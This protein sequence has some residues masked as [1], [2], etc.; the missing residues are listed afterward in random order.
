MSAQA[1]EDDENKLRNNLLEVLNAIM[2]HDQNT[3]TAGEQQIKLLEVLDDFAVILAELTVDENRGLPIR[4]L[5]SLVLKQY[6]EC[7]WNKLADKFSPPETTYPA[8]VAIRQMLPLGL[9]D[10]SSKIRSSI[11]YAISAI[12]HWDWP[13]EWP[14][15]FPQLM[16]ALTSGSPSHVHGAMRVLTEFSREL[17]DTQMPHVAPVVLPELLK[18]FLQSDTYSIRT[19]SRAVE[20]F[21]TCTSLI[22]SADNP[23]MTNALLP[24]QFVSEFTQAF[25]ESLQVPNGP[26][27]DCGLKK[28][29]LKTLISMIRDVP[30]KMGSMVSPVLAAVWQQL[31]QGAQYYV[32]REVNCS[33]EDTETVFD[34]DGEALSFGNLVY[35]IFD[36]VESLLDSHKS[37]KIVKQSLPELIYHLITY[38]QMTE[39]QVRCWLENP[40]QFVEDE[41]EETFSFSVR[42]SAQDLFMACCKEFKNESAVALLSVMDRHLKEANTQRNNGDPH[43]WKIHE[44]SFL[45]LG[46]VRN[47]ILE[48]LEKSV[49]Q[50]DFSS[51]LNSIVSED[52]KSD[53]SFLS[54]RSLWLASRFASLMPQETL[55]NFLGATV[56][57]LQPDQSPV[58]RISS[59]RA[60][61]AYCDH[62]PGNDTLTPFVGPLI[63]GLLLLVGQATVEVLALLLE[64]LLVII[65]VNSAVTAKYQD[66]LISLAIAVILKYSSDPLVSSLATDVLTELASHGT[67]SALL[68]AKLLPTIISIFNSPSS[69]IPSGLLSIAMDVL[70]NVVRKL[71]QPLPPSFFSVAFPSMIKAAVNSDDNAVLQSAGE[72]TRSYVGVDIDQLYAW[73]DEEGNSGPYYVMQLISMLLDPKLTEYSAS[74]A[75]RLV[76]VFIS[77]SGNRLTH[78]DVDM[79][80]RSVLSKLQQSLTLTVAQ[81]LLMVFAHLINSNLESVIAFLSTVPGPG[82]KSAMKFVMDEWCEKQ[83]MFY[84]SYD[85]K[86]SV[87]A[88]CHLLEHGVS[89]NDSRLNEINVKGD[90]IFKEGIRTRS[91]TA[92]EPERW[93]VIPLLVKVYKLLVNELT[94]QL[95][96]STKEQNFFEWEDDDEDGEV[97][98]E[99]GRQTL[100]QLLEENSVIGNGL[101]DNDEDGYSETDEDAQ[102]DPL[103]Q[104][105]LKDYLTTF[106][107]QFANTEVHNA[108]FATHL[109]PLE[110]T[111]LE[112]ILHT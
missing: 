21:N 45:A 67:C 99:D 100:S 107:K 61:F 101:D 36:F 65:S 41:D 9:K 62:L 12:A 72:C 71:K 32:S 58:I 111:T 28:E 85:K 31:V 90:R 46:S 17:T 112:Q 3:R 14:D 78:E 56:H 60:V 11:A 66:Q 29:V 26:A 33:E 87:V 89:K 94:N 18:I 86:V 2:S 57:G 102:N 52:L 30:R 43:W 96:A 40:D 106:L 5:A 81:S 15:L 19:R 97:D 22:H 93:T 64:S 37:R 59:V 24:D 23:A 105:N 91:R 50:F 13:E 73:N 95:E 103:N 54:G 104:I 6:V 20:I 4:Q 74:F 83:S 69:K 44:A 10:N 76:S 25:A 79:V 47:L 80:L 38:M 27:S 77:K 110:L 16:Q 53:S 8:K 63:D 49:I 39:D 108:H 68:E 92:K 82:G 1:F 34:S 55:Q 51:F 7:H 70:C 42:I 109:N 35:S 88:L 48:S 98:P 75:G 84:G